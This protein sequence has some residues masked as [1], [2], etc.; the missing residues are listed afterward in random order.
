ML[1]SF[2]LYSAVIQLYIYQHLFLKTEFKIGGWSAHVTQCSP[3]ST[4]TLEA[5]GHSR[6]GGHVEETLL[7]GC[8]FQSASGSV[9]TC[10]LQDA[11]ARGRDVQ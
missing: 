2:L 9:L 5:Q 8:D 6:D 11:G 1:C 10:C 3:E 4:T 7:W